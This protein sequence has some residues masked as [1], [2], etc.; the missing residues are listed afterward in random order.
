MWLVSSVKTFGFALCMGMVCAVTARAD[1][2]YVLDLEAA[3]LTQGALHEA[4]KSYA[5][6]LEGGAQ[7][8][9]IRQDP[10]SGS[11]MLV[12]ATGPTPPGAAKDR[13]EVRIYSGV[14]FERDWFVG[15]DVMVPRGTPP[16]QNWQILLQ[17]HQNGTALPPPLSLDLEP[18]GHLALVVRGDG[19]PF[20]RLWQAPLP[21]GRWVRLGLGFQMGKKGHVSLW[22]DGRRVADRALPLGWAAGARACSL[23]TGIYRGAQARPFTLMLDNIKMGDTRADVRGR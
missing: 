19:D 2:Y 16:P 18:G 1:L 23:K 7:A 8:P 5:I 10:Q 13:S 20:E 21:P 3:R 4:R 12:M 11:R 22:M 9:V 15:L 6:T 17:C 14:A